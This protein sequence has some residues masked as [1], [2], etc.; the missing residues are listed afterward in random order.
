MSTI[1]KKKKDN[2][3]KQYPKKKKHIYAYRNRKRAQKYVQKID[4]IVDQM[5]KNDVERLMNRVN[6]LWWKMEEKVGF[7]DDL[8]PTREIRDGV[9]DK[10]IER[11][12]SKLTIPVAR[13]I[14]SKCGKLGYL[15]S[16]DLDGYKLD[17]YMLHILWPE[18]Q[19]EFC[20]L[21]KTK[22]HQILVLTS[23]TEGILT[24]YL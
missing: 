22:S 9:L 24:P 14:C 19:I 6:E 10:K 7:F 13:Y 23:P 1:F 12:E 2:E 5:S 4:L 20:H 21:G 18:K 16:P 3:K 17:L 15:F 8:V 11:G